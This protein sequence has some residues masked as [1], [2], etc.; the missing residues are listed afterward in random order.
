MLL[1]IDEVRPVKG[2]D[3]AHPTDAGMD[4]FCPKINEKLKEDMKNNPANEGI[5]YDITSKTITIPSGENAVIPSGIKVEIPYGHM[6]LFLNKSGVAS[7]TDLIIGAQVIDCFANDTD[8]VIP[9]GKKKINELKVGDEVFSVNEDTNEIEK[10]IIDA[11]VDTGIQD[12]IIFET[13]KGELKVTP[14][15]RIYTNNGI[16]FARDITKDDELI[17]HKF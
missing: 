9:N 6:G 7:K 2:P 16:K 5:L 13:D 3:R 8:I 14:G 15:S 1:P 11:V 17:F 12:I 4:F 10:D